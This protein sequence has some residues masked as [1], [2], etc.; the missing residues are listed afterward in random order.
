[1]ART[2]KKVFQYQ[3]STEFQR[4]PKMNY[5]IHINIVEKG[6]M[7]TKNYSDHLKVLIIL[8]HY[9]KISKRK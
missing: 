3:H 2:N 8:Y 9:K 6:K 1:M 5:R 7:E 4:N